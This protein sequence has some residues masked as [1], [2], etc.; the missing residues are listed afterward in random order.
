MNSFH[1]SMLAASVSAMALVAAAPAFAQ[2]NSTVDEVV[3][4]RKSVV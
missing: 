3:V 4:D 2:D 1:K